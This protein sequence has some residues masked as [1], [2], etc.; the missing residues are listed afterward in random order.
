MYI[1]GGIGSTK[2]NEG[3][4]TDYDLPNLTA[5]CETCASVGMVLWNWR[6]TLKSGDARYADVLEK[7]LYNGALAGISLTGDRFFYV[8]PL[9]SLGDHHRKAWYGCA[10]CPSQICR[11]L[12]SIGNYIYGISKEALWVN[13]FISSGC[14]Y[15][16]QKTSYP[17][18]GDIRFTVEEPARR[19]IR[20]RIPEWCDSCSI[21]V[22]GLDREAP[23]VDGY[24]VLDGKWHKGD[25]IDLY[26]DIQAKM[27]SADPRVKADEGKRAVQRG[28]LVYCMEGVDNPGYEDAF[29]NEDTIL[30]P[31]FKEGLLGGIV[32]VEART[33][34]Q[35]LHFIPYFAWD[36]RDAGP[37]KVWVNSPF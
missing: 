36:N 35:T 17:W 5:Y 7:A 30:I 3:F 4:T 22:N 21:K 32:T 25:I 9:E 13:L 10:C 26:L 28:P 37:M 14:R 15:L 8:N 19:Q 2:K 29:L 33:G 1:T 11:F 18:N 34:D 20:I 12:P 6:M 31:E 27:V 24:A 16:S 23:V